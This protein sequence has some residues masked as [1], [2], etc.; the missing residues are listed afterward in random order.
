MADAAGKAKSTLGNSIR[1]AVPRLTCNVI[2][3]TF[4]KGLIFLMPQFIEL[5]ERVRL[6]IIRIT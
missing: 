2:S 1:R 3:G 4:R 5:I 6:I